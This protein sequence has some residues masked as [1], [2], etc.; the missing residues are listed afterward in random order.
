MT[1]KKHLEIIQLDGFIT[2]SR[3][4]ETEYSLDVKRLKRCNDIAAANVIAELLADAL[5]CHTATC[6]LHDE[7]DTRSYRGTYFE[8]L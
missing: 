4:G 6:S 1:P 2:I 5:N 8:T 7:N 3:N